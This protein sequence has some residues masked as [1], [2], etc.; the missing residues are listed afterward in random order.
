MDRIT[1]M[2]W[3]MIS[4]LLGTSV[5]YGISADKQSRSMHQA[6]GSIENGDLIHLIKVL[7]GDT[8]QAGKEGEEPVTIRLVGIKSFNSKIEKDVLSP[9]AQASITT[10]EHALTGKPLRVL[11]NTPPK[12]KNERYLAT[13]YADDED[14]ALNLIRQGLVLVYPVYPF[15]AMQFYLQEQ[16]QARSARRGVWS[17]QAASERARALISEWRSE[18]Q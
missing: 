9:Y 14:I 3:T 16:N 18:S 13:L 4:L 10:L 15:P 12:D 17:H 6:S 5:F 2:F 11:L 8:L 1:L 7:D